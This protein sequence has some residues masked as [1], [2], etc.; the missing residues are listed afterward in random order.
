[1][2]NDKKSFQ[3]A[4]EDNNIGAKHLYEKDW[5]YQTNPGGLLEA[6]RVNCV[7]TLF[8]FRVAIVLSKKVVLEQKGVINGN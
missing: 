2:H 7:E 1:M 6:E 3:I 4:V 5:L 8:E